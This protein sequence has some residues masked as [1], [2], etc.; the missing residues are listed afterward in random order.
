MSAFGGKFQFNTC[1]IKLEVA[2]KKRYTVVSACYF[3][4]RVF[5]RVSPCLLLSPFLQALCINVQCSD[6]LETL[7][8]IFCGADVNCSTGLESQPSPLSL[9]TAHS[10]P[11]QAELL[12]HNLNTGTVCVQAQGPKHTF[13][14]NGLSRAFMKEFVKILIFHKALVK[15][16]RAL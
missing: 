1:T 14:F 4:T 2:A 10:Q 12:N 9:A 5:T 11:L 7:S 13:V 16:Q 8:L 6:V 3:C 15:T